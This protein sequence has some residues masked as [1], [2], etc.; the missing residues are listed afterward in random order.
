MV[1][2]RGTSSA[3]SLDAGAY[4]IAGQRHQGLTEVATRRGNTPDAMEHVE[5][6]SKLFEQHG[7]KR[8]LD[9]VIAKELD[10]RAV[11]RHGPGAVVE[12]ERS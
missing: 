10:L 7:A 2:L 5:A 1:C 8:Y 9:H 6:V 11:Q 12:A 4:V 3:R